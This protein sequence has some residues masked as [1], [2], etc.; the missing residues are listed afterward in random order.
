MSTSQHVHCT[1]TDTLDTHTH[2]LIATYQFV[3][4]DYINT[5]TYTN[6]QLKVVALAL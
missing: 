1:V 4:K 6:L 2:T 5:Q 3:H